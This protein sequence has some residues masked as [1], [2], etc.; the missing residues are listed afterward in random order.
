MYVFPF[1]FPGRQ[2]LFWILWQGDLEGEDLRG[3]VVLHLPAGEHA[4]VINDH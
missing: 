4:E 1:I 2:V 3:R